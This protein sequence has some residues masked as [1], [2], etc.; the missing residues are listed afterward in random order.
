[1][2]SEFGILGCYILY[3]I[4]TFKV[5]KHIKYDYVLLGCY[6]IIANIPIGVKSIGYEIFSIILIVF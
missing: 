3:K 1:M 4:V 2:L 6:F 5:N